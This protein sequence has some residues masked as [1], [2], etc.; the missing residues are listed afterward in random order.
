MACCSA[1]LLH[2]G[3]LVTDIIHSQLLLL[4]DCK[5]STMSSHQLPPLPERLSALGEGTSVHGATGEV[6]QW[7]GCTISGKL[8]VS[9][10]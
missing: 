5:S 4:W 7:V 2:T 3:C 9:L 8:R 6:T 10:V 1:L